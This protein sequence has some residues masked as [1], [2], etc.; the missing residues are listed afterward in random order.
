MINLETQAKKNEYIR[1]W[2]RNKYKDPEYRKKRYEYQNKWRRGE[3]TPNKKG[4][5]GNRQQRTLEYREVIVKY[6]IEKLGMI[7]GIC[8]ENMD[9]KD[10]GIDH[11]IARALGGENKMENLRL[12]HKSC[13]SKEGIKVRKLIYGH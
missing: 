12:V 8:N 4:K 10:I 11:I 3:I 2:Y 1:D 13:N 7:C 6:L 9:Y 5:P